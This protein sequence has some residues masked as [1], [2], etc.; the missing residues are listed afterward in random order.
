MNM[1]ARRS[2]RS[3]PPRWN[4]RGSALVEAAIVLPLLLLL[5]VSILEFGRLFYTKITVE[6]AVRQATRFAVTGN[7]K[8]DPNDPNKDL[9]RAEAIKQYVVEHAPSVKIERTKIILDPADGG[10]PGDVV[11]VRVEH[12]FEFVTPLIA[13]FFDGG[14][15]NFSY[16]ATMKN[17]PKFSDK[18]RT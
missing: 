13:N 17:E 15:Y 1:A 11:K 4:E 16:T 7:R 10:G 12:R 3:R 8:A 5:L 14:E 18:R 9:A 6:S 2:R